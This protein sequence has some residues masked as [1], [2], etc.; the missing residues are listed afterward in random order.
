VWKP[1]RCGSR[2]GDRDHGRADPASRYR[3][4]IAPRIRQLTDG[5]LGIDGRREP[6]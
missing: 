2:T 1:Q 6:I 3:P 5:L 4:P